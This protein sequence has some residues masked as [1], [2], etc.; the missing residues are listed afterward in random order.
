MGITTSR[1]DPVAGRPQLSWLQPVQNK[2]KQQ[3]D[4]IGWPGRKTEYWLHTPITEAL[5]KLPQTDGPA[6]D[7]KTLKQLTAIDN[8]EAIKL[9]FLDGVFQAELSTDLGS[10]SPLKIISQLNDTEQGPF[11]E[12][13]DQTFEL[14][15]NSKDHIGAWHNL[16]LLSDG[17]VLGVSEQ[18]QLEQPVHAVFV[19]SQK[20]CTAPRATRVVCDLAAGAKAQLIEHFITLPGAEGSLINQVTEIA[21]GDHAELDHYRLGLENAASVSLTAVHAALGQQANYAGFN[22][23]FGGTCKRNDLVIH[24]MQGDSHCELKGIYLPRGNEHIDYHTCLEH[25]IPQCTSN[26]VFRGIMADKSTAVFNGR[27]HIHQDAQKTLAE[28]SNRNLLISPDAQIY[29]KPELEI[30]ADDVRC[31]H[32]ATVAQLDEQARYYLQSRG[33][34]RKD[35]EVILSFAFIN[36]LI[37]QIALG[38]VAEHLRPLLNDHFAKTLQPSGD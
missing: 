33:I 37:D 27:I 5:E 15:L 25:R 28:L 8:L 34:N 19:A 11:L 14:A 2:G 1:P 21:L 18:Q 23:G 31:A 9:V 17:I 4:A 26:E 30:Y 22:I 3:L 32:G 7:Q 13:L 20:S 35:A 10:N 12:R 36:E 29:T 16:S 24:H 38:P 6:L